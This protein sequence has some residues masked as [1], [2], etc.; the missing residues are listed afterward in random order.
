MIK[1]KKYKKNYLF[2]IFF[3][4]LATIF[5]LLQPQKISAGGSSCIGVKAG[6]RIRN[7]YL[8]EE[9]GTKEITNFYVCNI[10]GIIDPSI[11]NYVKKCLDKSQIANYGLIITMDTPGGLEDSMRDIVKNMLNASIPVIVFVYPEGSRAAS[12][13]VFITYASDIAVMSPGTSIGAAHPVN[14]GGEEQISEEM[15]DKVVNDSVSFIINLA[16]SKG[17]NAD[18]AE[19]AVRESVSITSTEALELEV[20][21]FTA[22]SLEELLEKIDGKTLEKQNNTFLLN[23]AVAMTEKIE[24]SFVSRF[25]HII[26]N[27]NIAYLLFMLGIFGII[28]EFSQPGLGISGAIGVI[29]IILGLYSFS[30]LPINY[31]GLGLIILAII[32]FILDVKLGLGGVMSIA[33]IASMLLGSF[34]LIDTGAPYLKIATSLIIGIT[35]VIS[36]FL[37]IAIRA[38]Y[39]VHKTKPVTGKSGLIGE[40]GEVLEVLEPVGQIKIHGEIWKALSEDSERIKKGEKVLITSIDGLT[41]HVKK[42]K[43]ENTKDHPTEK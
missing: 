37:I 14:L 15:M 18:W 30:I 31:A 9:G 25:L 10:E 4:L 11:S 41:L 22:S 7:I 8:I 6:D 40:K 28:Y 13:G 27:P 21:D 5:L 1:I 26:S 42:A 3:L 38:V 34:L 35:A 39:K 23:S 20:I 32:L 43:N 17:R 36:G 29:F 19:K 33:G 16:Q 24:M 2:I 12:A